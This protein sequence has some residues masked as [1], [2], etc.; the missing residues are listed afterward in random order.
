MQ[1]GQLLHSRYLIKKALASGGFGQTYLAVDLHLPSQP[2]VVVKLLQP[3]C[4]DP[5]TFQIAKRLFITEADTLEQLGKDSERIPSLYAYFESQGSFYLVQ[6]FIAGKTLTEEVYGKKISEL[7]TLAILQEILTGLVGLHCKDI[8][9]RDLKPD[10]IIRRAS[11][12]KLI[13]IDFGAVKQIRSTSSTISSRISQTISIGTPGYMPTEQSMGYPKPASDIYAVGAIGIQCLTGSHPSSLFNED[14]FAIEWQHLTQINQGFTNVL[15]KMIEPDYRKRY[16]NAIEALEAL[17]VVITNQI[18]SNSTQVSKYIQPIVTA[19]TAVIPVVKIV[20]KRSPQPKKSKKNSLRFVPILNIL[21]IGSVVSIV[22]ILIPK[23]FLSQ[24]SVIGNTNNV[25]LTSP[26][27]SSV[28]QLANCPSQPFIGRCH[29]RSINEN[30]AVHDNTVVE[31]EKILQI[32]HQA[33]KTD[34]RKSQTDSLANKNK[35]KIESN[36][37][38]GS[39]EK[40]RKSQANTNLERAILADI[41][42]KQKQQYQTEKLNKT[43]YP[44]RSK[45]QPY[46]VNH[47]SPP[48][49]IPNPWDINVQDKIKPNKL[50]DAVRGKK[51]N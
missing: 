17:E 8:I 28:N 13:L 30:R 50:E 32:Q 1:S 49:D 26:S 29:D 5:T 2:L 16:A 7:E 12:S 14:N 33:N 41:R 11:D 34:L 15:N 31:N 35:P 27:N 10:N 9:H 42:L 24:P 23:L 4:N 43:N 20:T 36:L 22:I 6:E 39:I 46:P 44:I 21:G 47:T 51:H 38:N 18:S 19:P 48:P 37:S 3:I 25:S 45:H 40:K